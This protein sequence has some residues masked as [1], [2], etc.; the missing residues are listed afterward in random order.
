M[1]GELGGVG[2]EL[3]HRVII[4]KDERVKGK[5]RKASELTTW[6]SL[7]GILYFCGNAKQRRRTTLP[8]LTLAISCIDCNKHDAAPRSRCQ[9]REGAALCARRRST[10]WPRD[11]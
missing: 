11:Q 2:R 1:S 4:K 10:C 6:K 5:E 3:L 9:D 8:R 7:T